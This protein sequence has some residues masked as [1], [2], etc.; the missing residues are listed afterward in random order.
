MT[1]VGMG[2]DDIF[3]GDLHFVTPT[4]LLLTPP[5]TVLDQSGGSLSAKLE[6]ADPLFAP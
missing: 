4:A 6:P 5:P 2:A 1:G 3:T